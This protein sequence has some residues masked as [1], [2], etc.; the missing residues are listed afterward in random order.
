MKIRRGRRKPG[1]PV[2]M[3]DSSAC[4][5][6]DSEVLFARAEERFT[7][8]K[9]DSRLPMMAI[10]PCLDCA[11]VRADQLDEYVLRGP[12]QARAIPEKAYFVAAF[13]WTPAVLSRRYP[14]RRRWTL[15]PEAIATDPH[16]LRHL[17]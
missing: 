10:K 3:H 6:R 5:V 17:V 16:A 14:L 15:L 1:R 8:T 2:A 7:L 12:P 13:S 4:S 11:R 9:D